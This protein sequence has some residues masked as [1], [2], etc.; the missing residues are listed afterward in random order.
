M[1]IPNSRL[2]LIR[3]CLR[4]LGA[5]VIE[6]N[7]DDDQIDDCLDDAFQFYQEFH[8]DATER[9]YLKYELT[10]ED[11]TNRYITLD[12]SIMM[13]KRV[14]PVTTSGFGQGGIFSMTYQFVLND[15]QSLISGSLVDY[16]LAMR[17]MAL[18]DNQFSK[19]PIIEFQRH[20]NKL[21]LY[22]DWK[23]ISAG[24][25]IVLECFKI[26]DPEEYTKVYNDRWLKEY[27]T[28]V[29][30]K[31]WGTNLKKYGNITLPGG[32][33]LDGKAIYDEAVKEIEDLVT[34][35]K[36]TYQLPIDIMWG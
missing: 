23:S 36:N 3:H 20:E 18:M 11:I 25:Y 31:Q 4:K 35:A 16:N 30:K 15:M 5:P 10:S 27:V 17:H 32:V 9:M 28:A 2:T 22:M 14:F 33:T 19:A 34:L 7:L 13:V 21:N 26:I 6:I 12:D 1:G 24:V 8:Y 29:F